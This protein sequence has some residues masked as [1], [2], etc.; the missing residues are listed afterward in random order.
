MIRRSRARRRPGLI[1]ALIVAAAAIGLTIG[2][3]V[4]AARD[5]NAPTTNSTTQIANVQ[6][7]C[8]DWMHS[9]S[10]TRP[11][12]GW[13]SSM[14]GW[15]HQQLANGS[16]MGS[17][18]WGDADRMRSTCRDWATSTPAPTTAADASSQ[19]C[20]DMVGWMQQHMG[21]DWNGWM[22]NGSMMGR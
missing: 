22:R 3:A 11:D 8:Q 5:D 16:M 20:D 13:C 21:N 4:A 19:W 12:A 14:T 7:A 2:V 17:M 9:R 10:G 18:M 1:A 6:Q 15:M